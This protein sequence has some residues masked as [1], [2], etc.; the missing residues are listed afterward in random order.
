[1]VLGPPFKGPKTM[2][3]TEGKPQPTP[4]PKAEASQK[5]D[6]LRPKNSPPDGAVD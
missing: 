1:M 3:S 4:Q 2:T 6:V 5:W